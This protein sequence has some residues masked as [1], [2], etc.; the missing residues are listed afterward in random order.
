MNHFPAFS[1]TFVCFC[2][3]HQ[4]L[5]PST[6][7]QTNHKPTLKLLSCADFVKSVFSLEFFSAI[8]FYHS[9]I[10]PFH[11]AELLLGRFR[12]TFLLLQKNENDFLNGY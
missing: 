5:L 10:G 2:L 1:L 7:I 3:V 12:S 11:A 9:D 4:N 8:S 6:N